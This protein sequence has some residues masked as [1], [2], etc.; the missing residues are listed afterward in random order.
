MQGTKEEKLKQ[1]KKDFAQGLGAILIRTRNIDSKYFHLTTA[2]E[3]DQLRGM[4]K[5]LHAMQEK[6]K[7]EPEADASISI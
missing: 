4:I 1:A 2:E 6:Y 7:G 5:N 3:A